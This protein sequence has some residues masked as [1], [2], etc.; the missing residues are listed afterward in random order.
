MGVGPGRTVF[1]TCGP[2]VTA[3]RPHV[4]CPLL[5]T[6][7]IRLTCLKLVVTSA[8][9]VVTGA[10]LVVTRSYSDS[11]TEVMSSIDSS[12]NQVEDK[13]MADPRRK[14]WWNQ[15]M[16]QTKDFVQDAS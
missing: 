3:T 7:A 16:H 11:E 1:W 9:L 2:C 12:E 6:N 10:L 14:N 13:D 8:T 15:T 5:H 4:S